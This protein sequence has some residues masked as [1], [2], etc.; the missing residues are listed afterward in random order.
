MVC[1]SYKYFWNWR[2]KKICS[3]MPQAHTVRMSA[4][5]VPTLFNLTP[6]TGTESEIIL[7]ICSHSLPSH[8]LAGTESEVFWVVCSHS[9]YVTPK[10]TQTVI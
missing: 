3:A 10:Q 6:R 5:S 4:S 7:I 2:Q 1:K 9:F 8:P